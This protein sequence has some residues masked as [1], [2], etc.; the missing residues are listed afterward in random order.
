MAAPVAL[1]FGGPATDAPARPA[2]RPAPAPA[3]A[4]IDAVIAHEDRHARGLAI[5]GALADAAHT[6]LTFIGLGRLVA[7]RPHYTRWLAIV[8]A[9]AIIVFAIAS[10]RRRH[11]DTK[12]QDKPSFVRG[13]A[14]GVTLTCSIR[15]RSPRGS[16]SLR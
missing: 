16:Q 3:V 14:S 10:W 12:A 5:G 9:L 8:A 7:A 6:L 13:L 11:V 15:P 2:P 4:I 1:N